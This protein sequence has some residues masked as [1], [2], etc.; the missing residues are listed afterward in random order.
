MLLSALHEQVEPLDDALLNSSIYLAAPDTVPGDDVDVYL[1]SIA[2]VRV[3]RDAVER[4][5]AFHIGPASE[6]AWLLVRHTAE[7]PLDLLPT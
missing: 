5:A 4:V 6:E 2:E 3:D 1:A 7:F